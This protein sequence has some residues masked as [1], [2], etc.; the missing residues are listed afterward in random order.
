MCLNPL[1]QFKMSKKALLLNSTYEVL[2]FIPERKVLKLILKDKAEIISFWGHYL[3]WSNGKIQY[4]SIIRLKKYVKIRYTNTRFSRKI[5]I[6]RDRGIC[7]YCDKKIDESQITIDHIIPKAKGGQ[8]S[9]TNCVICCKLC[10]N[11][12]GDSTLEQANMSLLRKPILPSFAINNF[13]TDYQENWHPD[14]NDFI[15]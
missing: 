5:L 15:I 3:C 6:K 12:K 9:F 10:N 2:S 1:K 8:T 4:P 7:Q 13:I 11:K 14:W